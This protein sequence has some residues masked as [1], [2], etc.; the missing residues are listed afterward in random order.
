VT[1]PREVWTFDRRH[2]GRRVLVFD[3]LPSTNDYA[4][5]LAVDPA[6]SGVV[7]LAEFQTAGRGQYG[8]TW[9]SRPGTSILMSAVIDPPDGLD[10]PVVLTAWAAVSVAAA[11]RHLTG[12]PA[13]I[14]WPNDV[15]VRGKKVCGV[16]I[17]RRHGAAVVAGIGLNVNQTADEFAVAELPDA[18]SLAVITGQPVESRTVIGVLLRHLDDE[19]ARLVEVGPGP[20]ETDWRRQLGLLGRQVTAELADGGIAIG[21]VRQVGF[22]G[23]ELETGDGAFR[24]LPAE[25][26]RRMRTE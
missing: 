8:R 18:T 15:L 21:R 5:A 4:A 9:Q 16:L 12:V 6:N 20:L 23:L 11:V 14:K 2:V 17:E 3:A 1:D 26:V 25:V 24:V 22:D 19:F 10:R 13:A 7:V